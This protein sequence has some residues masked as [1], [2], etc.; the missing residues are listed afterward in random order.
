MATFIQF[1]NLALGKFTEYLLTSGKKTRKKTLILRSLFW[2]TT[3]GRT[4]YTLLVIVY[5]WLNVT[6][7]SFFFFYIIGIHLFKKRNFQ[8]ALLLTKSLYR[9]HS[10]VII[11]IISVPPFWESMAS[12]CVDSHSGVRGTFQLFSQFLFGFLYTERY[13]KHA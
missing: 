13:S 6:V 7:T 5:A 2:S 1:N 11:T 12:V 4:P 10:D 8:R 3:T 9:T